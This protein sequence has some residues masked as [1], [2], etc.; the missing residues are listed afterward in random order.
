MSGTRG[1]SLDRALRNLQM[2]ANTPHRFSALKGSA[3]LTGGFFGRRV[4]HSASDALSGAYDRFMG[5]SNT[6]RLTAV[7][8]AGNVSAGILAT[9]A[10]VA[11]A[12][13]CTVAFTVAMSGPQAGVT[14]GLIGLALLAKE[15]YSDREA[16]H[17]AIQPHVWSIVDNVQ[18]ATVPSFDQLKT[19]AAAC[20]T[21][22]EDGKNQLKKI[23]SKYE[24]RYHN[25]REFIKSITREID[26][27]DKFKRLAQ[28]SRN[29]MAQR[30][31]LSGQAGDHLDEARRLIAAGQKPGGAIWEFVRR[32]S[33][34]SNYIQAS[35]IVALAVRTELLTAGVVDPKFFRTD[36]FAN[37]QFAKARE[38]FFATDKMFAERRL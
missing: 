17:N 30:T 31:R 1:V 29:T 28:N 18:P 2:P 24:E 16:A 20:L 3:T 14:L 11:A 7:A 13:S 15:A 34:I 21:L 32:C 4:G 9:G 6:D 26:E 27:S 25:Y 33:H 37:S 10:S 36:F 19:L 38:I 5:G 22:Q 8:E 35:E 12:A 23:Q